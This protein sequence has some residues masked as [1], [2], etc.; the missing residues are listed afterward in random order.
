[1]FDSLFDKEKKT[2]EFQNINDKEEIKKIVFDYFNNYYDADD[3]QDVWFEKMKKMAE[4]YGYAANMKD[5]KENEDKYKGNIT[6]I[7]TVIRV[8]ITTKCQSPDLYEILKV[9]G[10]ERIEK[11]INNL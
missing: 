7:A 10:K 2:Y 9:L 5:Y 8:A 1:M 4:K 6:D 11:R 3:T